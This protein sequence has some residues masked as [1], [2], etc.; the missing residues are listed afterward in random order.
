MKDIIVYGS[1]GMAREVVELIEDINRATPEWNILGYI[2]DTKGESDELVHGYRIL[3]TSGWLE[4]VKHPVYTV[5]AVSNPEAKEIIY[6]KIRHYPLLF[7]ILIHP[8][9]RVAQS[10]VIG[11]GSVI[12]ID[13]IVSVNVHIGRHVFLNMR[14]VVGHDAVIRDFSSCLVNCIVAGNVTVGEKTLIGSG[15]IIMEKRDIGNHV[16]I[17]M[18]SIVSFDVEDHHVVMSRP[19]KSMYFGS[20]K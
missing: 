6:Q 15:S 17:G 11:E 16:R 14:T 4:N 3:G 7:P 8:S 1:G 19:S 10:A 2:D 5:L 20:G 12:G 13:C 18:G 9:A